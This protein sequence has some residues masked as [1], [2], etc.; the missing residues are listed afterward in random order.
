METV[1]GECG[2]GGSEGGS[3]G[4]GREQTKNFKPPTTLMPG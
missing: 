3:A 1:R 2:L 4:A